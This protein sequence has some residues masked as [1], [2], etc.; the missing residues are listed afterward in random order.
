MGESHFFCLMC[1]EILLF[2][3]LV[4]PEDSVFCCLSHRV[5][6]DDVGFFTFVPTQ[7]YV[8]WGARVADHFPG[9]HHALLPHPER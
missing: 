4:L 2:L 7:V 9:A 8:S 3:L 1:S 6:S 5:L